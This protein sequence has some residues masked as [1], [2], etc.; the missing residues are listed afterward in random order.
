[1]VNFCRSLPEDRILQGTD[2][3]DAILEKESSMKTYTINSTG[4]KLTYGSSL[5]VLAHY[6]SSLVGCY[7]ETIIYS[8]DIS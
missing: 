3:L 5:V 2:S 7:A 8:T 1:M 6:A 4:A